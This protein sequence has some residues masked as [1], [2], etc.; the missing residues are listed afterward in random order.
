MSGI[1]LGEIL[2]VLVVAILVLGPKQ[3]P[4]AMQ[5]INRFIKRFKQIKA[6]ITRELES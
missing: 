3:L 4:K 6:A 5:Y 2:L 1:G